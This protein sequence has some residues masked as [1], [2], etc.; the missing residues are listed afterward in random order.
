LR[1]ADAHV[2]ADRFPAALALLGEKAEDPVDAA[3][4][5]L[6]R[7]RAYLS[8][9]DQAEATAA[10]RGAY[11]GFRG[12][13]AG[14]LLG[15][16]AFLLAQLLMN[17]EPDPGADDE[18]LALLGEAMAHI[19]ADQTGFRA[20]VH[21]VRGRRL[22][23]LG[24]PADAVEDLVEAVAA[25]TAEG[26]FPQMA[27]TRLDLA[28]ALLH[29][30]RHLEAAEA[31]EEAGPMLLRLED[32][33]AERRS[34]YVAAEAQRLMGEEGAADTFAGLADDEDE[35][36]VAAQLLEKAGEVLT[37]RDRDAQA[38][39][40]FAAAAE[41][42]TTAGDPYGAVRTR[43]RAALCL[44]WS[45]RLDDGLAE[46]GAVRDAL[47]GL[48]PDNPAAVTWETAVTSYDEARL[49]ASAG[50]VDEALA[51]AEEAITGF[52]ALDEQGPAETA[53]RLR[54]DLLGR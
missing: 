38:A 13:D 16:A 27:H 52:T 3:K 36:A 12:R 54:D 26:A 44:A 31:A 28:F 30:G 19:P 51:R 2:E 34:R 32:V 29:A 9:G 6:A 20:S 53:T 40:R 43:R 42:F 47:G 22:M 49:L 35:P 8:L 15:E 33:V 39:E 24:R 5:A 17:E 7:G 1:L 18:P 45:G 10:M 21:A 11:E 46:M 14:S 37:E 41:R 4:I 25:F 48:P 50:R 23:D